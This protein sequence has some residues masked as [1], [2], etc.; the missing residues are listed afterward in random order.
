MADFEEHVHYE[1][2]IAAITESIETVRHWRD[3]ADEDPK[4]HPTPEE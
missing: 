2:F 4:H 1:Q 3:S